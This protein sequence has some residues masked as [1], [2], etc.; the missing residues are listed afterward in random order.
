MLPHFA[1]IHPSVSGR[2]FDLHIRGVP[3]VDWYF[4]ESPAWSYAFCVLRDNGGGRVWFLDSTGYP[5]IAETVEP[6][7][8]Q[9]DGLRAGNSG[10][11]GP[12]PIR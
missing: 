1:V 11:R 3:R 4:Q 10:E 12:M 7:V 5:V 9:D 8:W 2:G 6:K